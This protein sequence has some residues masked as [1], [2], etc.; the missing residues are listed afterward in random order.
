MTTEPQ[1]N[2]N[3][4]CRGKASGEAG[5]PS[6]QKELIMQNKANLPNTQMNVSSI[7]TKDYKNV[8]PCRHAENKPNQTQFKT[9]PAQRFLNSAF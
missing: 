5:S 1:N 6:A 7:L 2:A 9:S 3:P 4:A 8:P